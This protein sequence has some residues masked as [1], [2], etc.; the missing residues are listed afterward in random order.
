MHKEQ[1]LHKQLAI[2]TKMAMMSKARARRVSAGP[3]KVRKRSANSISK[4]IKA[5]AGSQDED[6]RSNK[7]VFPSD[8]GACDVAAAEAQNTNRRGRVSC[9]SALGKRA[10]T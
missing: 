10:Q 4:V 3:S 5:T 7:T 1:E 6:Q 2:A 8:T 9:H